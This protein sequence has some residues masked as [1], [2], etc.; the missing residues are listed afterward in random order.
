MDTQGEQKDMSSHQDSEDGRQ[1]EGEE[2]TDC[3][4][5]A[6]RAGQPHTQVQFDLT[7]ERGSLTLTAHL[8]PVASITDAPPQ[9]RM[10]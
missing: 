10:F 3:L 7:Q 5:A 1:N 4:P 2:A 6:A 8:A 9:L